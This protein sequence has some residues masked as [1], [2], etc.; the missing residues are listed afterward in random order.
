MVDS[1]LL[2]HRAIATAIALV[3]IFSL[4]I[5]VSVEHANLI[6]G[7]SISLY[8]MPWLIPTWFYHAGL[9]ILLGLGART[10][11]RLNSIPPLGRRLL[12]MFSLIS[13]TLIWLQDLARHDGVLST[14]QVLLM[15]A[16]ILPSSMR[17]TSLGGY[18]PAV[19]AS[20]TLGVITYGAVYG[21]T[22]CEEISHVRCHTTQ[23]PT[24]WVPRLLGQLGFPP[25]AQL[26]YADLTN[27]DLSGFDL[28]YANFLHAKLNGA[29]L[30]GAHLRRANL[31][32]V[33]ARSANLR[34]AYLDGASLVSADLRESDLR[35][36]HAYR[37]NLSNSDLRG[38]DARGAS[39]SH[40]SF[41]GARLQGLRLQGAYL[42]FTHGTTESQLSMAC[43]AADT[44]LPLGM[45]VGSC[46]EGK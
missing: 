13:L 42:R 46:Q 23:G 7:R 40:A 18:F 31:N 30:E 38:S 14:C 1:T 9:P 21:E 22:R 26:Q 37:V 2:F 28:R 11:M 45:T 20:V 33:R 29:S 34:R 4:L 16:I 25:F 8:G 43:G 39:F 12:W 19:V 6:G 36:V 27:A 5:S 17:T 32:Q 41:S 3:A 10:L 35:K 15:I 24:V 44:R